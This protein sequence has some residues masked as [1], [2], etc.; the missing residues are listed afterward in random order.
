MILGGLEIIKQIELGN[1]SIKPLNANS[2]H[3]NSVD[4]RLHEKLLVYDDSILDMRVKPVCQELLI[5]EEGLILKPN[6][7]YLG[8]TVEWTQTD[9]F[10]PMIEGR[11]SVGRL[12]LYIHV[13][14][15]FGDAGFK[16]YW[17]LELSCVQ[18]IRIYANLPICQIFYHKI[19]GNYIPY[20][21]KYQNNDGIQPSMLYLEGG[22]ADTIY[23]KEFNV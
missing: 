2:I 4:L 20:K 7:L 8:R 10:V 22:N 13:T 18:P 12:G 1:I 9:K 17:T 21:S 23:G 6:K 11:S 15:G 5:P 14:A 3:S 19:F 16:G